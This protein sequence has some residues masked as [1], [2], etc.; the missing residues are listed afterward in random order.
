[1]LRASDLVAVVAPGSPVV[2]KRLEA[3]IERLRS[4]G[5]RVRVELHVM[6][7]CGYL[8]GDDAG[9][10]TDFTDAWCDPE[11][12]AVLCARGGYGAQRMIDLVDWARLRATRAKLF[13]G[14][15]DATALHQALARQIGG[16]S[17]FG[18]MVAT[19][20]FYSETTTAEMLRRALFIGVDTVCAPSPVALRSG[21]ADGFLDGGNLT[22]LAASLG[23]PE[24]VPPVGD[25]V[26][27][28]EDVNEPPWRLDRSLTQL[29][30]AGWL[31]GVTAVALGSFTQC[32]EDETVRRVL[33]DRL[34]PLDIPILWGLPV[35]HGPVQLTIPLGAHVRLDADA[36]I[37]KFN[38]P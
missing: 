10:A 9:R 34:A 3:G 33:L 16:V 31:D 23:G 19:P 5:L 28:L 27:F 26:L 17:L 11:V 7:S 2:G 37:L 21:I 29:L 1:M 14:S 8:A 20:S 13:V 4:W 36:G 32:G 18:P 15:S 24:G 25:R 6:R 22:M 30:R 35:G 12:A 38:Y